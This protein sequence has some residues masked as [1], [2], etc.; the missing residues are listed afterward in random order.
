M[1][2]GGWSDTWG[3]LGHC[4]LSSAQDIIS[5]QVVVYGSRDFWLKTMKGEELLWAGV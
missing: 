5:P 1:R 2:W 3:C 4:Y